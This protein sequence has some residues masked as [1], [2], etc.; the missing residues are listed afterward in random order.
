MYPTLKHAVLDLLGLELR[1]LVLINLL[2]FF[3]T[4]G[5]FGAALVLRSE[6]GRKHSEGKLPS[7]WEKWAPPQPPTWRNVGLSALVAF[8]LGY[9]VLGIVLGDYPLRG[10]ADT[11]RYL[12]SGDGDGSAGAFCALIWIV[13]KLRE[14]RRSSAPLAGDHP[15]LVEVE[16]R[17]HLLGI[18]GSVALGALVGAKL[19]HLLERPT[20]LLELL[21]HPSFSAL[22]SGHTVYGGLLLG[23]LSG[24]AYC[25]RA[26]L[27]FAPCVDAAAPGLMLGYGIGRLG[28]HM[29]GDGD[30]GVPSHGAPPGFNWLP[31]WFWSYDYPNNVI[32]SGVALADGGYPGYGT[33]LVP[34]VYPT[35]LYEALLAS[36]AF[37]VLWSVRRRIGRPL[38][39]FGLYMV[40]NGA[41]RFWIEKIR[42]N[43]TYDLMG[44][45]ATQAEIIAVLLFTS[46]LV[47]IAVQ[48][49]RREPSAAVARVRA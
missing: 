18:T 44:N 29:A 33:H 11:R 35:S 36:L 9:K 26:G 3:V 40:L 45:A 27:P 43:A 20:R 13:L 17:E 31:S 24:Y 8:V 34:G 2:G 32:H 7:A 19:F 30:W 28:C 15:E 42:V 39:M 5:F 46:G 14:R 1:P 23:A 16:P 48:L 41:E 10:A 38:V 12:L 37:G 47:L 4:L 6:L 25:R 49:R 21:Q 22:F